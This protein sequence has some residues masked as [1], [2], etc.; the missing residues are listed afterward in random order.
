MGNKVKHKISRL[1][2][3]MEVAFKVGYPAAALYSILCYLSTSV[4]ESKSASQSEG[5]CYYTE[6]N[7]KEYLNMS[8]DVFIA[9]QKK[10]IE[11]NL[12]EKK[13]AQKNRW[14]YE[15]ANHFYVFNRK[16]VDFYSKYK[17]I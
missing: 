13:V 2:I 6:K 1:S 14:S 3:N 16:E 8:R 10:L 15:V 5:W 17:K 12:I 7:A 9:S 11:A 4:N